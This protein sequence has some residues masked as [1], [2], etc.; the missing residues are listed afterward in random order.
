[1]LNVLISVKK[2]LTQLLNVL[3]IVTVLLL[4]ASVVWGVVTRS[5]G[6]LITK[7]S[8]STGWQPWN[9]LPTGQADWTEEL[10]RFLL[11]W[12]S[13]IGAAVAFGTKAHLGVDFFVNKLDPAAR[14][15]T[16]IFSHITVLFF[17]IAIFIIGGSSIVHNALAVQQT[18][19]ALGW[20]MGY[21][22]LALP[23][24]GGFM[25]IYTLENLLETMLTPFNNPSENTKGDA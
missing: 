14:K 21:V 9:W 23:I 4:V 25:L 10:A 16:A 12:V 13:L 20:K 19:P 1:M 15:L 6:S 7:I 5:L 11:V 24:A 2:R 18:T 3:L 22:Y 17:A 8:Q